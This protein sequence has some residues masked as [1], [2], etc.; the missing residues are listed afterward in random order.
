V[1]AGRELVRDA[2]LAAVVE[3]QD[4]LEVGHELAQLRRVE[5]DAPA[6]R[7]ARA[8]A[9][10]RLALRARLR[11]AA[12]GIAAPRVLEREGPE[13]ERGV[14]LEH[15]LARVEPDGRGQMSGSAEARRACA[16]RDPHGPVAQRLHAP[17][18]VGLFALDALDRHT[19][20]RTHAHELVDVGRARDGRGRR[21]RRG[22]FLTSRARGREFR[23]VLASH[24][25]LGGRVRV[26]SS[27]APLEQ[28]QDEE[29]A[30]RSR[31]PQPPPPHA[32]RAYPRRARRLR[33]FRSALAQRSPWCAS[34]R[35]FRA[36]CARCRRDF[37]E[38]PAIAS[39][40]ASSSC[41][42]SSK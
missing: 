3:A 37:T 38:P 28:E 11:P 23:R 2:R 16:A 24:L 22:D 40:R 17:G 20:R 26:L 34:R 4:H 18:T 10:E 13:H 30:Q 33:S 36:A 8:R 15:D 42:R 31:E 19:D 29:H 7:V 14:R 6:P 25:R 27:R 21:R 32:V 41:E 9:H 35:T 39:W 12:E 1:P 5:G